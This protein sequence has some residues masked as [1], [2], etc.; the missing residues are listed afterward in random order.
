MKGRGNLED[1]I[2]QVDEEDM[3]QFGEK[4]EQK[5]NKVVKK[6]KR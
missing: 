2:Y 3:E 5:K 1:A 6:G 4:R